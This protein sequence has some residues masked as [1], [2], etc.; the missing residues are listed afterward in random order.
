MGCCPTCGQAVPDS[1]LLVDLQ[2]NRLSCGTA[3]VDLAPAEAEL[4]FTLVRAVPRALARDAIAVALW[5][6][7]LADER[8]GNNI[9]V[10]LNRLRRRIAPLGFRIQNYRG[11]GFALEA[12]PELIAA[13]KRAVPRRRAA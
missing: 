6:G 2:R 12:A 8:R 7:A 9:D 5:G 3:S 4:L 13:A 11:R 1:G 10:Y